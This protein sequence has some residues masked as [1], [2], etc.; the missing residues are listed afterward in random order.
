M[1]YEPAIWPCPFNTS[2][3]M[4]PGS[5]AMTGRSS[6]MFATTLANGAKALFWQFQNAGRNHEQNS[7]AFTPGS[8]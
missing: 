2:P 6:P 5:L 3:A 7:Y 4:Q 8:H 1:F